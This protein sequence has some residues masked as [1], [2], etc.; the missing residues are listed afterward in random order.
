MFRQPKQARHYGLDL[1]RILSMG[2]IVLLHECM[3]GGLLDLPAGNLDLPGTLMW[4]VYALTYVAVN[5]YVLISG[6]FQCTQTF[7]PSR[8]LKTAMT[9]WFYSCTIGILMMQLGAEQISLYN[10]MLRLLPISFGQYWF[11]TIY[12]GMCLLTP[13]LNQF[14]HSI[15]KKQHFFVIVAMLIL[16]GL[17]RDVLPTDDSP[18][19]D[20][21]SYSLPLFVELYLIAAYIRLYVDVQKIKKTVPVYFACSVLMTLA[22]FALTWI[23]T[24]VADYSSVM[25]VM[26]YYRNNSLFVIVGSVCVFIAFLKLQVKNRFAIKMIG[27]CAPLTLGVYAI[28]EHNALRLPMWNAVMDIVGF[29]RDVFLPIKAVVLAALLF[30]IMLGIDFVRAKLFGLLEQRIWYKNMMNRLDNFV[31]SMGNKLFKKV[32]DV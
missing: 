17:W 22:W 29:S 12:I 27:T 21:T 15:T 32:E 25:P 8:L 30:C 13:F 23:Y 1:L 3:Y 6:Y 10:I 28:H 4:F 2:L 16:L 7:K 9:V 19:V 14:I 20:N 11:V 24:H 18:V 26:Y 5:C 31:L